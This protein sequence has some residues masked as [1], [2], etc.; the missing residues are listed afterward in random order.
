MLHAGANK[1]KDIDSSSKKIMRDKH[2]ELL[3]LQ[4]KYFNPNDNMNKNNL[5]RQINNFNSNIQDYYKNT[6]RNKYEHVWHVRNKLQN[7]L[8]GPESGDVVIN[9]E[10]REL[11][12]HYPEADLYNLDNL[13]E[14]QSVSYLSGQSEVKKFKSRN[15]NKNINVK[16]IEVSKNK[17]GLN[18][19]LKKKELFNEINTLRQLQ[20]KYHD[21]Y[22]E[23][24]PIIYGIFNYSDKKN[25]QV[26]IEME[27]MEINLYDY[28]TT[29]KT[30]ISE[31]IVSGII[32]K[33]LFIYKFLKK[34]GISHNDIKLQNYV[35][36]NDDPVNSLKIID[37]GCVSYY[38]SRIKPTCLSKMY[39]SPE[40]FGTTHISQFNDEI[41]DK[42]DLW[43]IGIVF[44]ELFNYGYKSFF[45]V[46][47]ECLDDYYRRLDLWKRGEDDLCN[48]INGPLSE[49]KIDF[50]NHFLQ[51]D[52]EDRNLP[53]LNLLDE[54]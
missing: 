18:F 42:S 32:Q 16:F 10:I 4:S 51:F 41:T 2:I 14:N 30:D 43:S 1:Y 26:W 52:P 3:N 49:D 50:L 53:N 11:L 5:K 37:F 20:T 19:K 13:N 15:R 33:I 24:T 28:I 29:L 54:K 40:L 17:P 35:L 44:Y 7:K 34:I 47:P 46:I 45:N 21:T 27:N 9:D 31:E 48:T 6:V 22:Q 25:W 39:A 36:N 8:G 23:Y 12:N 38:N